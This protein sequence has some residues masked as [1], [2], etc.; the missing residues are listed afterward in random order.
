MRNILST[1]EV[2]GFYDGASHD[3][4]NICGDGGY[5]R[6]NDTTG[7]EINMEGGTGTNKREELL[8]LLLIMYFAS[9]WNI[10]EL[11]IFGNSKVI[12]D[13]LARRNR[14]EV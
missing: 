6:F 5:I 12:V 8:G 14:L 11:E 2:F 4:G 9:S 13:W 10:K 1:F 3:G 7:Y